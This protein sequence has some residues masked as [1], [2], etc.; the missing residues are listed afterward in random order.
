MGEG[1][2]AANYCGGP[3]DAKREG[4][5]RCQA[6]NVNHSA[7]RFALFI[8]ESYRRLI[9]TR[10]GFIMRGF[11]EAG[12][13]GAPDVGVEFLGR[14]LELLEWGRQAWRTVPKDSRGVIFEDTFFRGVQNMHLHLFM[15]VGVHTMFTSRRLQSQC[16]GLF[17]EP[18]D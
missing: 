12:L 15:Q 2:P 14:A 18:R 11:M 16:T 5:G 6:G 13:R 7:V 8:V 1:R 3:E 10:S 9:Q 17:Q 4:V